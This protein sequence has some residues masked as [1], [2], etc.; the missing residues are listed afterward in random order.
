MPKT[1]DA[2]IL[3][4]GAGLRLRSITGDGPKG[5]A[6]VAGRPFLELLLRQLRRHEFQ[7]AILAVGY[8]AEVI[9]SYFGGNSLDLRLSYSVESSPLGTGG[10]IRNAADLVESEI[11]LIMNGDSYTEVDLAG[12]LAAHHE[13][14]ADAHLV[15]VPAD[16]RN[17]SGSVR[18]DDSG[19]I[20]GFEEKAGAFHTPYVSAGIYL[21]QRQ[22]LYDI[23][24]GHEVSLEKDILPRWLRE[25]RYIQGFVFQ[26]K[27]MD[28][29]TPQRFREAQEVLADAEV[30]VVKLKCES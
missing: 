4:G 24:S 9:R 30:E 25:G 7:R 5:M 2:L 21:M 20:L 6:S 19:K 1:P 29:G 27:C 22:M 12:I 17:D 10:A 16:D 28:I 8:Q 11:V 23:P 13:S 3:C 18:M 15:L 26:G 14:K